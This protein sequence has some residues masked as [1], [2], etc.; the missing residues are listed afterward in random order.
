[1]IR[2]L[3]F[4]ALLVAVAVGASGALAATALTQLSLNR[5]VS[6]QVI[7]DGNAA[8]AVQITCIDNSP[9]SGPNYTTVCQYDANGKVTLDLNRGL[10]PA[11]G[12]NYNPDAQFTLG[13]TTFRVVRVTNNTV[14]PIKVYLNDPTNKIKMYD[15]GGALRNGSA[16]ADTVPVGS[17][18]EYYFTVDTG[19]SGSGSTLSASLVVSQ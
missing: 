3:L 11:G 18:R 19:G 15:Q 7:A 12:T 1:M 5:T 8:A 16:N 6:A 13:S 14:I 10:K 2:S 4:L 17:G 9:N